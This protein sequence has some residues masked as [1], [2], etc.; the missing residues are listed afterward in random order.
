[1]TVALSQARYLLRRNNLSGD[2]TNDCVN[3][4][5]LSMNKSP[6]RAMCTSLQWMRPVAAVY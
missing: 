5:R 4:L 1:M 6:N 3:N 2:L